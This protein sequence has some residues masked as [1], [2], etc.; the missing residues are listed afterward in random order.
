MSINLL[1]QKTNSCFVRNQ[2]VEGLKILKSI[3]I[4]YPDNPRLF[5]E[6]N[7]IIKKYKKQISPTFSEKEIQEFF[8][9]H[10]NGQTNILI[11][12]MKLNF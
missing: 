5:D 12:K 10:Y 6:I 3:W 7:K 11:N 8:K 2:Q 1:F 4:K 9:M